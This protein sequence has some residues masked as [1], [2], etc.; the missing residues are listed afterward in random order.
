MIRLAAMLSL[1][2]TTALPAQIV[3]GVV[4]EDGS[5]AVLQGVFI[6]LID[7]LQH[8]HAATLT[9]PSGEYILR[10]PFAGTFTLR[11]ELI[12]HESIV[13]SVVAAAQMPMVRDMAIPVQAV[14]LDRIEVG[15]AKRCVARPDAARQTQRVWEEVRKAL[16]VASWAGKQ[17]AYIVDYRNYTRQLDP[18]TMKQVWERS[19]ASSTRNRAWEA[20]SPDSLARYGFTRTFGPDSVYYYG[21]DAEVLLSEAFLDTHCFAVRRG[22][23]ENEGMIG[24]AFRPIPKR[25]LPEIT[26]TLW[27]DAKTA[28]LLYIEYRFTALPPGLDSS[29]LGGRTDFTRLYGGAWI[30]GRWYIRLP[31]ATR[32]RNGDLRLVGISE[33]GGEIMGNRRTSDGRDRSK[34]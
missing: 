12:G 8:M 20:L 22:R 21:A 29:M 34:Q 28:E 19:Y 25:K 7:S 31:I 9:N 10:A 27:I 17:D 18:Y 23:H 15:G 30:V 11:A 33:S 16:Q 5:G 2:V 24:L 4:R 1:L 3:R 26:G 13:S 6:T 32:N 14:L